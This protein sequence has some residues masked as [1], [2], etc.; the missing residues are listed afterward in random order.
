[1]IVARTRSPGS[2]VGRISVNVRVRSPFHQCKRRY[3]STKTYEKTEFSSKSSEKD[4]NRATLEPETECG[5]RVMVVVDSS[6][7]SKGALH[8]ALSHTVQSQDTIILLH[9]TKPCKQGGNSEKKLDQKAYELLCTMKQLCQVRRPGVQVDIV[10]R[11]GKEKGPIIV[12]DAK[13]QRISLLLLGQTSRSLMW[14]L[15][16]MWTGKRRGSSIVDYCIQNAN[17]MT[18]AVRKKSRKNGGYLITTKSH[19]DFWLLA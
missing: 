17:C 8:W 19:K 16:K 14:C 5:N 13:Q 9:V 6:P 11:Q 10:L 18:I 7:E 12:K 2:C 4:F 15:R 3:N 1:M